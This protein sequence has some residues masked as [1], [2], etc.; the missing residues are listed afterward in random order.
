M[1][2]EALMPSTEP[3]TPAARRAG[4]LIAAAVTVF[5]WFAV[6]V[7]PGWRSF[8]F[9]TEDFHGESIAANTLMLVTIA[10][11]VL[12]AVVDSP[13][14]RAVGGLLTSAFGVGVLIAILLSFPFSF[15]SGSVW[16]ALMRAGLVFAIVG[17]AADILLQLRTLVR[18]TK[19][20]SRDDAGVRQ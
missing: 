8:G 7:L 15:A 11:Y 14:L 12:Y 18:N 17:A 19:T 10:A 20:K 5:V 9:I 4:Y 13:R 6:F 16:P 3:S 1:S 2:R